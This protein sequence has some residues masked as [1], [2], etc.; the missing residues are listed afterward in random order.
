MLM[1]RHVRDVNYKVVLTGEGSDEL[2]G[3]YPAFR[4]DMF[5]HGLDHLAP[6]ERAEWEKLL[7]EQNKLFKGAM[8]A[9]DE[10]H[11]AAL[12]QRVG[13]TPSCLQPWLASATRVPGILNNDLQQQL[14]DYDPGAAIA[15]QLD[16]AYLK[17]RHPLDKA[18][19]VWIK[20]MLEGQILTW[21]GDRV[22][23]ANSMEARPAFLDHHL[24]ELAAMLPPSLRIKGKT[25]KYVL[26][27][28]MKGLLPEVLYKR[29]KFA[30]MAPPAH[31]DPHKWNAMRAL[32]DEFLSDSA[33]ND[34]GL[35]STEGVK[36][37][38]G[39]HDNDEITAA[40][41]NKLDAVINHMLGVQVLHK[42]FVATDVPAQ[43]RAKAKELGWQ[44]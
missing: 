18:Q 4:R 10:I 38:F 1:S 11:N 27:E 31:T 43:A 39:L 26:R 41:Q 12:E 20:T 21:G 15:A 2:F 34:A 33:I 23:M 3:G 22:D 40:T 17:D 44:V 28:A 35:L 24:A 32:A 36:A 8:L 13:F 6:A 19:Y 14:K 9:E 16:E 30:F 29:E 42:H 5:L 7:A 25:E 37:L